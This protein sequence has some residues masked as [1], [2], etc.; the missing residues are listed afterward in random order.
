MYR[1]QYPLQSLYGNANPQLSQ[2]QYYNLNSAGLVDRQLHQRVMPLP[3]RAGLLGLEQIVPNGGYTSTV[4]KPW[5]S[6]RSAGSNN[7]H[8]L[9][10]AASFFDKDR[11]GRVYLK[12]ALNRSGL[13][14]FYAD[15]CGHCHKLIDVKGWQSSGQEK[16]VLFELE[17]MNNGE[18]PIF[19][20]NVDE[21]IPNGTTKVNTSLLSTLGVD[22][23]PSV[24]IVGPDGYLA[25][26]EYEGKR[27]VRSLNK[28]ISA[29]A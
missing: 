1:P 17:N 20:V 2:Q 18:I 26:S 24:W 13:V 16:G 7:I 3:R 8:L 5:P 12:K 19:L 25:S 15:W 21:T 11:N 29:A 28:L 4:Y 9:R 27:D 10:N 6:D 23:F 14:V 22:A